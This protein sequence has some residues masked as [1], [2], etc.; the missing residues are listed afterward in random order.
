MPLPTPVGSDACKLANLWRIDLELANMLVGLDTWAHTRFF[1]DAR[2]LPWAGLWILSGYR[3]TVQQQDLNP[4]APNSLHTRCPAIAVDLRIGNMHAS[5]SSDA[6]WQW[7]GAQWLVMGGRWGG[8]FRDANGE[9][10]P[11]VNHFDLGLQLA[12]HLKTTHEVAV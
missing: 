2:G 3:T 1:Q 4:D 12:D 6:M 7:L 8:T 5:I 11:D 10:A 9:P